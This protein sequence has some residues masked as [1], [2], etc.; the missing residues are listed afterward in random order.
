MKTATTTI[1]TTLKTTATA[2]TS[3]KN[4]GSG[5]R[6]SNIGG[7]RSRSPLPCNVDVLSMTK[8]ISEIPN[9]Y[10]GRHICQLKTTYMGKVDENNNYNNSNDGIKQ[11]ERQQQVTKT[12]AAVA[13]PAIWEVTAAGH[14]SLAMSTYYQ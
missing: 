7:H 8:S 13:A 12:T 11:Q 10:W 3:N 6:T 14:R 9:R 2:A 5:S 4:N 1:A